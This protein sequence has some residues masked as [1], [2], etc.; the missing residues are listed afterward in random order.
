MASIGTLGGVGGMGRAM[1]EIRSFTARSFSSTFNCA[2]S[3]D[4]VLVACRLIGD[5][6]TFTGT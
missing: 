4:G 3:G 5:V 1:L 2:V 6:L